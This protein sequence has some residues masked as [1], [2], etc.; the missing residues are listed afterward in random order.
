M[1]QCRASS[2]CGLDFLVMSDLDPV[3]ILEGGVELWNQ[4]RHDN[5]AER[6]SLAGTDLSDRDLTGIN[7]DELD[8]TD[9]DFYGA[10]LSR[11]NLKMATLAGC[12]FADVTAVS[13]DMYKT[14]I[15]GAFLI[16][17]DL[18]KAYLNEARLD[19]ADLRGANLSGAKLEGATLVGCNISG[20]D[21]SGAMLDGADLTDSNLSRADVDRASV[22]GV[23][24]G[25]FESMRGHYFGIR[26][27]D[28]VFGNALFVRD[29]RDRDYI[30][31]FERSIESAPPGIGR[32]SRRFLFNAWKLIGY[33]RS[34]GRL[35]LYALILAVA[36]G[37]VF[38]LDQTLAWG[39]MDYSGS[40]ESPLTPFY[41]SIV[42]YTTLGF[43]DITPQH[44]LGE[45][46]IIIEVLL[47]YATLGLLLAIL[48]NRVA[49]QS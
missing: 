28:S 46:I 17:A 37:A 35:A 26:G 49:R 19:G 30:D 24:Y 21:L 16:G 27:L 8:L 14:D 44:W 31:A 34:L 1:A 12:D 39:L 22:F 3:S 29:A 40:A 4:W 36:F 43:G 25:S 47:G 18:S 11:A 10:N 45:V 6:P 32:N 48:G 20:S 41:F 7:L 23:R 9:V 5:P 15:Q 42:T 13:V 38:A 2:R 33:G